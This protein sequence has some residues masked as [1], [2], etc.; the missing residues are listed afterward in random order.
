MTTHW[1]AIVLDDTDSADRAELRRLR[2]DPTIEFLD[3]LSVQREGLARLTPPP[4]QEIL[5]EPMRWVHYPW[6]RTVVATLGP[7]AFRRLRLDR[8]RNKITA[9]EQDRL[10]TLKI[11]IVGLS[12]GHAIAYALALDGVCGALRLADFDEIELSNLNRIPATLLDLGI[13]KPIVAARRIAEIDPYLP[14]EIDDRGV[15]AESADSFVD[16]LDLV[17]EECDSLDVKLLVREHARAHGV[18]VIMETSDRGLLDV[19]RFDLEPERALFHGLLGDIESSTLKGLSTHDKVP[20]VL[21]LLGADDLSARMAASMIEV[22]R[23][24]TTWPQLGSEVG[25]GGAS[26]A[27]AVRRFG[28]GQKLESGRVR[29]HIDEHLDALA[30]PTGDVHIDGA[31]SPL[32]ADES[33]TATASSFDAIADAANRAPSGGNV[34]PWHITVSEGSI[35]LEVDTHR[36]SGLDVAYRGSHV[37]LGAALFNA[38]VAAADRGLVGQPKIRTNG[39]TAQITLSLTDGTDTDLAAKY[40]RVLSRVTNRNLGTPR[41]F[42]DATRSALSDAADAEGTR[43]ALVTDRDAIERVADIIAESDRIRYLTNSLHSEMISELRWP[44]QADPNTGIDVH[45]LALDPT[46]LVKL[47]VSRRSD[48]MAL[49]HDW[50]AGVALGEDSHERIMSSSGLAVTIVSGDTPADFVRGGSGTQNVW[51]TAEEHGLAVH[52]ASP[53][54]IYAHEPAEFDELSAHYAQAL[55]QLKEQFESI[56]GIDTG[57]SIALVL[58]L[59]HTDETAVRSRRRTRSHVAEEPVESGAVPQN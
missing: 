44:G 43:L 30:V 15:T 59:S 48:V 8:N 38:R 29:I 35:A 50:D 18:P 9:E 34:Q 26:V 2:D 5:D 12:V 49:L 45:A 37:A 7:A 57:E 36:T 17:I 25:L 52:P 31:V 3:T 28:L 10:S 55:A 42:D 47:D 39:D 56:V 13:T 32:S 33:T 58:R 54:F 51:I 4:P 1:Q 20:Y 41:P 21:A 24:T 19:E 53:V 23:T 14:I 40:P 27:G 16:G 11:G 46:D 6:R 22:D